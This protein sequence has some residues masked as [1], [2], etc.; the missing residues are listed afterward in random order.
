[1]K[2]DI[3]TNV[4][5]CL[6]CAKV[7]DEHQRP[8][9]LLVQPEIPQWKWDN[10]TMDFVTKLPKSSQG[11][12]T[13]WVIID[14]L[15]KSAIFTPIRETDSME[16][17][18]RM[19]L[20]EV[21]TRHGIPV[22]IICDRDPG[23]ESNFWRSLQKALGTNLDIS[24]T[25]HPQIDG[26]NKR[27]IQTLEDMLRA[28]VIN[29]G[30]CWVKH[31]P[32]VEFSYNNSYYASIK[33][34]SFE[35][36]YGR[37]CRSPICWAEV[38]QVQLTGPEI[39]Q[40]TT[41]KPKGTKKATKSRTLVM[42]KNLNL[43]S[44]IF[45]AQDEA[46]M[47]E[48]VEN[49][50]IHGNSQVKDNKIDLLVQQ[51]EQFTILKELSI[52]SGFA[53]FNT[54]ITSLK[55]LDEGFSSKNYVRKFLRALHPKWRAKVIAI[56]ESKDLSSIEVMKNESAM[57]VCLRTCL[58]PDEWIKDSGFSKY[59]IGNKSLFSTYK[60]YDRGNVVFGSNLK[61]K[62]IG[63]DRTD[64]GYHSGKHSFRGSFVSG[65][66]L[67]YCVRFGDNSGEKEEIKRAAK[68]DQ[69]EIEKKKMDST[70]T[71]SGKDSGVL[72]LESSSIDTPLET[73]LAPQRQE[74]SV[75]N[76]S[77][78]LVPQGQKASDYDNSDPVPPR[79]NV[80]PTAEKTD[81]SQHGL[82]F[83]F[84]PLLEEYYNPTHDQAEENNNDQAP[85]ASFQEDEF[86]NPFCTRIQ[87][88]GES[89]SRNIDNTDV[90][91]FQPQ[92]HDYR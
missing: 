36:L 10:I 40:E 35:A 88:I 9:G 17:L 6:T 11:Y 81:S 22:S 15:T 78:G 43:P 92:S 84:S 54:I 64:Y 8:L 51:Y 42:T 30:N 53:R 57:A 49:K 3:T 80:V 16:K 21:V 72:L 31:L 33:A 26:Q 2:T 65:K 66:L 89:S 47:K 61:G 83:L 44:Q 86:I 67:G 60:A 71:V 25:Y 29:F 41:E 75:E 62:I 39:V 32:L 1:M 46:I 85:N 52:D 74:M 34:A 20:K 87:E 90:H 45:N 56:E 91:S 48:N 37:K 5:K 58:E 18:A 55:A 14:R 82:E 63:K 73:D 13:I 12:D 38:G 23:F 76:V 24:T 27:T 4:N 70:F 59:M 68:V 69:E 28:C 19:Y 50:N 79:Q 7:K 77:S